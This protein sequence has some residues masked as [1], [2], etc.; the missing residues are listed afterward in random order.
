MP[1]VSSPSLCNVGIS[2]GLIE[3]SNISKTEIFPNPSN[4]EF[5]LQLNAITEDLNLEVYNAIGQ[6]V[7]KD[8]ITEI[9]S[10]ISL[11]NLPSG[12]Y[13]MK[14]KDGNNII[15]TEKIVKE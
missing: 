10:K 7:F 2:N 12:I 11:V 1:I 13:F 3:K 5:F 15:R 4:G 14:I 6:L 9:K 8:S